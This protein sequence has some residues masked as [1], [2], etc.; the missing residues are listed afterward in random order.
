VIVLGLDGLTYEIL[1]KFI[2][3]GI[4]PGFNKLLENGV[5]IKLRSIIPPLS[6]PAWVSIFTGVDPSKHSILGFVKVQKVNNGFRLRPISSKDIK[7]KRIWD[8]LSLLGKRNVVFQAPFEYPVHKINGILSSGLGTPSLEAYSVY[9]S[10]YLTRFLHIAP[11]Y[12][13]SYGEELIKEDWRKFL[14][15]F[16]TTV[17][18]EIKIA[19]YLFNNEK[20]DSYFAVFR[21]IDIMQHFFY[22]DEEIL[23]YIYKLYDKFILEVFKNMPSESLLIICSDHG[24]SNL[25]TLFYVNGWL[26][27]IGLLSIKSESKIRL[28]IYIPTT[29]TKYQLP[30]AIYRLLYTTFKKLKKKPQLLDLSAKL[31]KTLNI[32]V[33]IKGSISYLWN[34]DW[35]NTKA[36]FSIATQGIHII[37]DSKEEYEDI[38]LTIKKE[39]L[40]VRTSDGRPVIKKVFF[41]E[42]IY[43]NPDN[44]LVPDILLLKNE[45]FRLVWDIPPSKEDYFIPSL[46]EKGEHCEL[47]GVLILASKKRQIDFTINEA[48]VIDIT[49]TILGAYGIS[50]PKY[51][52]GISLIEDGETRYIRLFDLLGSEFV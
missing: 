2:G 31:M 12:D 24:F 16:L 42:E 45:G 32:D 50:R 48:S 15:K 41:K 20:W 47:N 28:P 4:L 52:D 21:G 44:Y 3:R 36:Y 27:E 33:D 8:L 13:V 38:R 35:N 25:D 46:F 11:H 17:N 14:A 39:I 26:K 40:K 10:E 23:S 6:P 7:A 34:I 5:M 19:N 9:P 49:P 29:Y 18:S 43:S 51:M 22:N 37:A 1:L 30:R